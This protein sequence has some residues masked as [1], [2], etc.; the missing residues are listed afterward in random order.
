[1][2]PRLRSLKSRYS[3]FVFF[4]FKINLLNEVKKQIKYVPKLGQDLKKFKFKK[5]LT[6]STNILKLISVTIM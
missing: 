5:L 6:V 3:L 1:M 2:T 4:F